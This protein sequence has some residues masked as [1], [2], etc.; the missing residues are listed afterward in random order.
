MSTT[1][2]NELMTR[3]MRDSLAARTDVLEKVKHLLLLPGIEMMT[4]NQVAAYFGVSTDMLKQ[5]YVYNKAEIDGDGV[6]MMR[7]CDFEAFSSDSAEL[8]G[9]NKLPLKND[10][11]SVAEIRPDDFSRKYFLRLKTNKRGVST[12]RLEDGTIIEI[13]N[14]GV[15]CFSARA[16]LRIAM[17]LRD[18][19][20][21]KEVRTQ[22]LN[23][24]EKVEPEQ[25]V[26]E[27]DN[28]LDL[29]RA[30]GDAYSKGDMN[31]LLSACMSY[32]TYLNRHID[33]LESENDLLAQ[34][35]GKWGFSKILNAMIR[36]YGSYAMGGNFQLAWNTFFKELYSAYGIGLKM[37][38]PKGP[39]IISRLRPEEEP[40]ALKVAT[41]MC[42][43][44]NINLE[45]VIN[46]VNAKELQIGQ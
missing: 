34:G 31:A 2:Q 42:L 17:L 23:V 5:V 7:P 6:R 37:R 10:D 40:M 38:D 24:V 14:F 16:I 43:R 15:R 19:E 26:V 9:N 46:E 41:A 33:A 8:R 1:T 36:A 3:E 12:F 22:L 25:R 11:D 30:I 20:V 4:A 29:G 44:K 45:S 27:I 18:S 32:N 21:A 39:T 28:E 13:Q 35:I